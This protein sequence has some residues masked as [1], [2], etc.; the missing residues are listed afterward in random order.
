MGSL[1]VRNLSDEALD[2]IR[3]R[4]AECGRSAEEIAGEILNEAVGDH[5]AAA[6]SSGLDDQVREL[7]ALVRAH[8]GGRPPE[9]ATDEFLASRRADWGEE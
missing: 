4:A 7:Q 8:H 9:G 2:R 3:R 1:T 6:T 5:A